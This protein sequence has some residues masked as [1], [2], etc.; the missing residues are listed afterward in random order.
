MWCARSPPQTWKPRHDLK[1]HYFGKYWEAHHQTRYTKSAITTAPIKKPRIRKNIARNGRG[2]GED[3]G[4]GFALI[5]RIVS[6][7]L[8]A[9]GIL[10]GL[11]ADEIRERRVC[12]AEFARDCGGDDDLAK[13]FAQKCRLPDGEQVRHAGGVADDDHCGSMPASVRTSASKSAVS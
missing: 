5:K 2:L 6:E 4:F 13:K 8:G 9:S 11:L 1:A 3:D 10:R 12:R 7:C